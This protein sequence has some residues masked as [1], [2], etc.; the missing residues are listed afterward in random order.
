MK[1]LTLPEQ[2]ILLSVFYLKE[3]AYLLSI[4]DHIRELAG[5]EYAIGTIYVPLER[6][7]RLGYLDVKVAKPPSKIGGRSTKFYRLT[8]AGFQILHETKQRQDRLWTGFTQTD[9]SR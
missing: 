7:R 6:L 2:Y 3:K 4:R 5:K 9:S 1:E 8:E